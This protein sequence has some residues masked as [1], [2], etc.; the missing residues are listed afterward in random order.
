MG[1]FSKSEQEQF[2]A[3]TTRAAHAVI[4]FVT[5][6]IDRTMSQYN[7]DPR[8]EAK[9]KRTKTKQQS[10]AKQQSLTDPIPTDSSSVNDTKT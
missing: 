8:S 2:E 4:S 10:N 5:D 9:T 6:G 3:A 1:K 7:N